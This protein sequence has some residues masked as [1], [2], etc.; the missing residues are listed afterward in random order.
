MVWNLSSSLSINS[1]IVHISV[2]TAHNGYVTG[3]TFT[4]DGLFLVTMGTD[5]RARLWDVFTG[6]NMLV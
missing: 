5:Q 3:M 4:D 1:C 2:I 6:I